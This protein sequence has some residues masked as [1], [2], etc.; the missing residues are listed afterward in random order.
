LLG[1]AVWWVT[2]HWDKIREAIGFAVTV[3][4]IKIS[5][6]WDHVTKFVGDI[7][8]KLGRL[9]DDAGKHMGEFADN[10][11]TAIEGIPLKIANGLLAIGTKIAS[12]W[13]DI[14]SK[15]LSFGGDLVQKV[16][17]GIDGLLGSLG[18][19]AAQLGNTIKN[20]VNNIPGIG[21]VANWAGFASGTT[22]AP[23]GPAR[24]A[25]QGAELVVG[26]QVR[27]LAAGSKV[28]TAAQTADILGGAGGKSGATYNVNVY[29]Q[30]ADFSA[31][32]LRDE[33]TWQAVLYG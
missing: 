27:N 15:A 17:D 30:K 16:I 28:Y 25:E 3:A 10:V 4:K 1:L 12:T 19:K 5:E 23:G 31:K 24:L 21:G 33:L 22:S 8:G 11:K 2:Q 9:K 29:P 14:K 26:P 7:L 32:D 18:S 20:A 6:L 13:D